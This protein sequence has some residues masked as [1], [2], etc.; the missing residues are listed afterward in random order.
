MLTPR[1]QLDQDNEAVTISIYAPFTHVAETEVFMEG[2]NFRFFSKPYFL[3]LHFPC[4]IIENE[5]ASAKFDSET[6]RYVIKC[7][8][9]NQG[10]HFPNL[11]MITEL[12]TPKGQTNAQSVEIVCEQEDDEVGDEWYFEQNVDCDSRESY[13]ACGVGFG[14]K[15]KDVFIKLLEECQE[16]LDIKRPD[17]KS[18]ADRKTE[19]LQKE[20]EDFDPDQ[21]L[22]DLYEP[23]EILHQI[24]ESEATEYPQSLDDKDNLQLTNHAKR[25]TQLLADR[26]YPT[27]LSIIDILFANCFDARVTFYEHSSESGWSIAKLSPTLV[28]SDSF[29]SLK[30]VVI[31]CSRRS[32]IYPMYRRFDLTVK[33]WSDLSKL[34]KSG[35]AS[36][37][38]VLLNLSSIFTES[39][40]RY[41]F[42]QL[43]IDQYIAWVQ[44]IKPDKF[45]K[46]ANDLDNIVSALTKN[47]LELELAELEAAA[48]MVKKEEEENE[49]NLVQTFQ[50]VSICDRKTE[51]TDSD[52]S[53]DEDSEDS[54]SDSETSDSSESDDK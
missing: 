16:I 32:L 54:D 22:F 5:D 4:E 8:K 28:C 46:V 38:K 43:F 44:K 53:S 14:Q 12:C 45:D 1:F 37:V 41:L 21:Y 34:L 52:D 36:I 11:D 27:F 19:R 15:H 30:E 40:G 48:E 51:N 10:E 3:R 18:L 23:D 47:D 25:D 13:S 29:N 6:L 7:P 17:S 39:E 2:T 31:A 9:V 20:N 26:K 49:D 35:R 42:N 24:I 33:V 50:K